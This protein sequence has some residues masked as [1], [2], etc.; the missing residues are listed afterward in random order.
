MT[1]HTPQEHLNTTDAELRLE[2]AIDVLRWCLFAVVMMGTLIAAQSLESAW[3]DHNAQ[4]LEQE[5]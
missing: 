5:Q 1:F 3:T 2:Y 4:R